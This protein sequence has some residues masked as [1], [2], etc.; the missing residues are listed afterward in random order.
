[1]FI[2]RNIYNQFLK[3]LLWITF[4]LNIY[5]STEMFNIIHEV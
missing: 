2:E 4:F 3:V 1:M 5:V